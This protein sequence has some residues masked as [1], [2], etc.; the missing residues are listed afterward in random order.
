[1]KKYN[2][3]LKIIIYFK[4]FIIIHN[5]YLMIITLTLN[6]R[7]YIIFP[8]MFCDKHMLP[9]YVRSTIFIIDS[10]NIFY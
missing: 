8:Q 5:I 6:I 1:M 9:S 4:M 2:I 7:S 10:T 3:Y